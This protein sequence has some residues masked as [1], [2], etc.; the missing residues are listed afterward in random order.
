[1]E[2]FEALLASLIVLTAPG[3]QDAA[4]PDTPPEKPAPPFDCVVGA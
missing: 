3:L 1:M 2:P 4:P